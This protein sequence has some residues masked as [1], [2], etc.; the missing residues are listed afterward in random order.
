MVPVHPGSAGRGKMQMPRVKS[1]D[2]MSE[3]MG[4]LGS[5]SSMGNMGSSASING[6]E[7]EYGHESGVSPREQRRGERRRAGGR[8][9]GP[10]QAHAQRGPRVDGGYRHDEAVVI[11]DGNALLDASIVV[12]REPQRRD[13]PLAAP[14]RFQTFSTTRL[15]SRF[16]PRRASGVPRMSFSGAGRARAPAH[17][18]RGAPAAAV[19]DVHDRFAHPAA[20]EIIHA[21]GLQSRLVCVT[22]RCNFPP[23]VARA[24]PI[25]LRSNTKVRNAKQGGM[26]RPQSIGSLMTSANKLD[27]SNSPGAVL[28]GCPWTSSGSGARGPG[29]ILTQDA[30]ERCGAGGMGGDSVVARALVHAGL[31]GAHSHNGARSTSDKRRTRGAPTR[32]HP[33]TSR[34]TPGCSPWTPRGSPRFS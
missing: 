30:C 11:D 28:P 26:S 7:D 32:V 9:H 33:G 18:E 31:L 25:V 14:G 10:A 8:V 15:C 5:M 21:L 19:E 3:T 17:A 4:G 29:L 20:T 27:S 2:S 24:F 13:E 6:G 22:D 34:T 23:S 16:P 1:T 12:Q